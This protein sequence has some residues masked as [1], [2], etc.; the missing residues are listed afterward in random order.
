MLSVSTTKESA[1]DLYLRLRTETAGITA[2]RD[3]FH[4]PKQH[5]KEPTDHEFTLIGITSQGD[6]YTAII[7]GTI[8]EVG[9]EIDG[10]TVVEIKKD[11]VIL[12]D[13]NHHYEIQLDH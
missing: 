13:E 8:V 10:Y 3:P 4:Q 1:G 9:S 6:N 2:E 12:S 7:N 5:L 11:R